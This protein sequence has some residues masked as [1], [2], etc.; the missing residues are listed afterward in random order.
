MSSKRLKPPTKEV[1]RPALIAA[2][3]QA[4]ATRMS[5]FERYIWDG[6]GQGPGQ[7]Y[8]PAFVEVRRAF[9]PELEAY[10][11]VALATPGG[12]GGVAA[13]RS[14]PSPAALKFQP[15]V[16]D[17]TLAPFFIAGYLALMIDRAQKPGRSAEDALQFGIGRYYGAFQSLKEAQDQLARQ[18]ADGRVPLAFAP[19]QQHILAAGNS[20]QQGAL[21]YIAEVMQLWRMSPA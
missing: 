15:A 3:E 7:M 1:L 14:A 17:P 12:G 21:S 20:K 16:T 10:L 6:G 8:E 11:V 4:E 19:L 18:A 9:A 13:G 2:I 5:L